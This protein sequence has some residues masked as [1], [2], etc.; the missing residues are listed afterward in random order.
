MIYIARP[1][2]FHLLAHQDPLLRR[3]ATLN[4]PVAAWL[5]QNG[6]ATRFLVY[7]MALDRRA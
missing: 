3:D 6:P 2:L 1:G 7:A 5:W 4:A